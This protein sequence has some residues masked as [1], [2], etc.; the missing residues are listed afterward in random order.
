MRDTTIARDELL[1]RRI[2]CQPA[3]FDPAIDP[4]PS[5]Q[6]FSPTPHD[7]T[8]L[9]LFRANYLT[10]Q[11]I[12][13]DSV[14]NPG[15]RPFYIATLR[16]A[17]L[18]DADIEMRVDNPADP[19]HVELPTIRYETRRDALTLNQTQLLAKTLCHKVEGPYN[20]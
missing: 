17:D 20:P 12:V 2:V 5:R 4:K 6:A 19:A 13:T 16:A 14:R 8:G 18:L 15:R 9:S 10:P 3:Y 1:Y 11:Q 7:I